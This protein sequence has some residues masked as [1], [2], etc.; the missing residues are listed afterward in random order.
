MSGLIDKLK[1][2]KALASGS[3]VPSHALKED[4]PEQGTVDLSSLQ[5]TSA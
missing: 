1:G 3:K 4:N 5:G 2:V